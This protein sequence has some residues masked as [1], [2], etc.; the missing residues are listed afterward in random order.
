MDHTIS[1]EELMKK[2]GF[3]SLDIIDIRD[4][5]KYQMGHI[6]QARNVPMNFLLTIPEN[7][8]DKNK[9]YYLCCE[10]G[11]RSKRCANELNHLGYHAVNIEG[12]Y[13]EYRLKNHIIDS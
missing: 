1:V 11:S 3:E 2:M 7:Y 5:Y 12:G 13:Q 10:F 6:P 4:Q 8:I 9:T